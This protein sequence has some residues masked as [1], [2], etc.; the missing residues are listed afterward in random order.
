MRLEVLN[1]VAQ[2]AAA[3]GVIASLFYLAAQIRQNTRSMRAIV[4]DSLAHSIVDLLGS[5]A[6][7][8]E[9]VRAFAAVVQDWERASD[10]ERLSVSCCRL[11]V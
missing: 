5:M 3:A 1:A 6:Q 7:Q 2:L 4:V 8:P 11:S 10:E 9:S